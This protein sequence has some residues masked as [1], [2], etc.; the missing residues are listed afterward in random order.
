[1][2]KAAIT[3]IEEKIE[4]NETKTTIDVIGELNQDMAY[5]LIEAIINQL[6]KKSLKNIF[7]KIFKEN[8]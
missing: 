6:T 8:L 7:M 5:T 3:I 4:K 2:K 1:M